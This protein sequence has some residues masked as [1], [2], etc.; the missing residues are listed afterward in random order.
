M[1]DTL[2]AWMQA[3]KGL[4]PA[5][6]AAIGAV[7]GGLLIFGVFLISRVGAP[8]MG[9][10]YGDL[11]TA[12]AAS[13]VAELEQAGVP[14]T[15]SPDGRRVMVPQDQ[16]PRLRLTLAESGVP[17]GGSV[18]YEIFDRSEGLGTTDF[19]QNVNLVR[20]LEGELQRTIMALDA[21]ANA[22]VHIVL[23]RRE[24]FSRSQ[25]EPTASIVVSPRGGRSLTQGQVRAIQQLIAAAVPGLR[26]ERVAIAD[27][28]GTLL[29]RGDG[30]A[31]GGVGAALSAADEMR[32]GIEARLRT[33][34]T[35]LIEESVGPGRVQVEVN[36]EIDRDRVTISQETYDPDG[37]V[38]RSR[39]VNRENESAV[40]GDPDAVTAANN[41]PDASQAQG[42]SGNRS[43]SSRDGQTVNYEISRTV[44]N[45][46]R[47]AGAVRRLSVAV[48]VDGSYVTDADGAQTYQPRSAEEL[49]RLT[50]LVRSAVGANDERG[51]SIEV[52]NLPFA[53]NQE[54]LPDEG[55]L[56][57]G[58][59]EYM[60][61]AEMV[62]LAIV[63]LLV[64]LLVLRPLVG[65]LGPQAAGAAGGMGGVAMV[66]GPDGMPMAA[67]SG[68][69]GMTPA[70]PGPTAERALAAAMESSDA[71]IDISQVEGRVRQSSVRKI[72]E[73]VDRHPEEA[74][75][76]I[77]SWIREED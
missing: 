34:V 13:V 19:A 51:D 52:V 58:A 71:M 12:D 30:G 26:P 42:Q 14:Y 56:G 69:D 73:I 29:A 47:E 66:T 70:L 31:D 35:R 74:L 59:S 43:Q 18:G 77:R 21:V 75:A 23:P 9:L 25:A 33:Q 61:I 48:L 64:I 68:P 27:D 40:D 16:I 55:L 50:Q 15:L 22:R 49:E 38:I 60:R 53:R 39:Q 76:V 67:L 65:R 17:K 4:G 57:L 46:V 63:A 44:R 11:D 54:I 6:L 36:A 32:Q 8:A 5:R 24:L 2:K 28:R 62:V 41:I 10:L 45:E 20:A 1:A 37:Q 72:A 7:A 3:L